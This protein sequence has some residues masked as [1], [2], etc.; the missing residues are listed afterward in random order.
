MTIPVYSVCRDG[1]GGGGQSCARCPRGGWGGGRGV[2]VLPQ[3]SV[4]AL[5]KHLALHSK[6]PSRGAVFALEPWKKHVHEN[7]G[8]LRG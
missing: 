2:L 1:V 8:A 3:R 6:Q 4:R 7:K 5:E